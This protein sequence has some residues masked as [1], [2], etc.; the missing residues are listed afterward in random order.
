[1]EDLDINVNDVLEDHLSTLLNTVLD[2]SRPRLKCPI[3]GQEVFG[4]ERVCGRRSSPAESGEGEI[5]NK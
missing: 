2:G 3:P 4:Q 5:T 1:M